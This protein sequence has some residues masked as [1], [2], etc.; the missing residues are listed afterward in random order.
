MSAKFSVIIPAH[1][2]ENYIRKTLHSIKNQTYQDYEV[3][4]V[5]NG[6]TDKTEEVVKKRL[7]DKIKHLSLNKANVSRA[8]NYGASKAVGE[9]L[10][11]LD[12]DTLLDKDSLQKINQS[13]SEEHS[14]IT[15]R[16]KPD[17]EKLKYKIG[18][19]FKNFY[20][21]TNI[22]NGCSGALVC[23]R[24]DFDKVNGYDPEL[25]VK[26]HRKL[27]LKLL[28]LG[29]FGCVDTHVTTSMRRLQQ[30]G[31]MG[32]TVFWLKQLIKDKFGKLSSSDYEKVR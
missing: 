14:V 13:F 30:W 3:I 22:Y 1:N 21:R 15:T 27:I 7:N 9:F 5:T 4:V 28:E 20:L 2:E 25:V 18:M 19:N 10:L 29:K 32:S 11:F 16:V 31:L 24:H 17:D 8:R 12:A 26:E 6:C 23:R